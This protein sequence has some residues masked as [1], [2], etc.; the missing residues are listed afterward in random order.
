MTSA[1]HISPDMTKAMWRTSSYSG[2]Q[3]DCVEVA[4]RVPHLGRS[5]AGGPGRFRD[6]S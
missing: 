3:G 1:V 2:G 4:D 6:H 5:R